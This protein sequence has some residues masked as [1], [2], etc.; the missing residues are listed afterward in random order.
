MMLTACGVSR[1][2][3][4][5]LTQCWFPLAFRAKDSVCNARLCCKQPKERSARVLVPR[6]LS[7]SISSQGK[8]MAML[9]SKLSV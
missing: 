6:L 9:V 8:T 1:A 3:N 2:F 4:I 5:L 7:K